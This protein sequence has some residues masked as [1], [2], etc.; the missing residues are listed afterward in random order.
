MAEGERT[1]DILAICDDNGSPQRVVCLHLTENWLSI[2]QRSHGEMSMYIA[3][4]PKAM[5][6][7]EKTR[8]RMV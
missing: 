6:E 7:T 5:K 4:C 1:I 2:W 3:T 8:K